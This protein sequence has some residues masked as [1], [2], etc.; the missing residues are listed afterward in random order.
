MVS[1]VALVVLFANKIGFTS[2]EVSLQKLF[3]FRICCFPGAGSTDVLAGS[4]E[5]CT[6][7][8]SG[9]LFWVLVSLCP[10]T[11]VPGLVPAY[12]RRL[13][14]WVLDATVCSGSGSEVRGGST[15]P[16]GFCSEPLWGDLC[17]AV[18]PPSGPVLPALRESVP[19]GEIF[20]API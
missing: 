6:E 2:I 7:A 11:V 20:W 13:A 12:F 19:N 8:T 14:V 16:S 5:P 9:L 1:R 4:T 10:W 18:V 3:S 17:R 15:G